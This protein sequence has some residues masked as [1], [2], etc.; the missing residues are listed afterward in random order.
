MIN[1]AR[2]HIDLK[3]QYAVHMHEE[4]IIMDHY[5]PTDDHARYY[6]V[7]LL[8][9]P[10]LDDTERPGHHKSTRY[11]SMR[12]QTEADIWPHPAEGL[13]PAHDPDPAASGAK[14]A[15][16][17][18]PTEEDYEADDTADDATIPRRPRT[19]TVREQPDPHEVCKPRRSLDNAQ[20]ELL[21]VEATRL[22]H[23][24]CKGAIMTLPYGPHTPRRA[25]IHVLVFHPD[26]DG[27]DLPP[28]LA[29]QFF[30]QRINGRP[31]S[32]TQSGRHATFRR[33]APDKAP[34]TRKPRMYPVGAGQAQLSSMTLGKEDDVF[35]D[36][37]RLALSLNSPFALL[38][39]L[40]L[41][42]VTL[43]M[44]PAPDDSST[45]EAHR[46]A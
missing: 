28:D 16:P 23:D 36:T 13:L 14:L 40:R 6:D 32:Q 45:L 41:R 46:S 9:A 8:G 17:Q 12:G 21:D 2:R 26:L 35:A 11:T 38:C 34:T 25:A 1:N 18:P 7:H 24:V 20:L 27:T 19:M 43:Y 31:R 29:K 4:G 10:H 33:Q 15:P 22:L 39:S 42:T 37:L 30:S 5:T 3:F 44:T